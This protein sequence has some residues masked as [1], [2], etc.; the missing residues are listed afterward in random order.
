MPVV[1]LTN[2]NVPVVQ[3]VPEGALVP[4][5]PIDVLAGRDYTKPCPVSPQEIGDQEALVARLTR[6]KNDPEMLEHAKLRLEQ[7]REAVRNWNERMTLG[8]GLSKLAS[9][10]Y[11]DAKGAPV[12]T[13]EEAARWPEDVKAML[14]EVSLP[15]GKGG[16]VK[17]FRLGKAVWLEGGA[18]MAGARERKVADMVKAIQAHHQEQ[19]EE[20][21]AGVVDGGNAIVTVAP[22]PQAAQILHLWGGD[23]DLN[24]FP[25][26]ADR[27][28]WIEVA[29]Q[30]NAPAAGFVEGLIRRIN[31]MSDAELQALAARGVNGLGSAYCHMFLEG[32]Q[33][34]SL[35]AAQREA[36]FEEAPAPAGK[37][38][39]TGGPGSS[40]AGRGGRRKMKRRTMNKKNAKRST[41]RRRNTRRNY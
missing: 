16:S 20:I 27:M 12:F 9:L 13:A 21:A 7:M 30:Q 22:S 28:H 29:Q 8:K 14:E 23:L 4:G 1:T 6:S 33:D 25:D 10:N 3:P 17:A 38:T 34:R 26:P 15:N 19:A 5:A 2:L 36:R 37:G 41:R 24:A 39:T 40:G 35:M 32:W 18:Q 31:R 11:N